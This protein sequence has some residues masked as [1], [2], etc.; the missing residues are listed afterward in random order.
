MLWIPFYALK[1]LAYVII[2]KFSRALFT[3]LFVRDFKGL[4]VA[5]KAGPG[6]DIRHPRRLEAY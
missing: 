3:H 5:E 2:D 4:P 6:A 1:C